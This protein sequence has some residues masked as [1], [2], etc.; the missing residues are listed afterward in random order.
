MWMKFPFYFKI[1]EFFSEFFLC[2]FV[3]FPSLKFCLTGLL[4]TD[5]CI[6]ILTYLTSSGPQLANEWKKKR[7]ENKKKEKKEKC[8]N[9]LKKLQELLMLALVE[10]CGMVVSMSTISD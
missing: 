1:S 9:F 10:P 5:K 3:F 7:K 6:A 4:A 8:R 2:F